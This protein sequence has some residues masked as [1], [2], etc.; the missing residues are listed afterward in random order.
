MRRLQKKYGVILMALM[1]QEDQVE[2]SAYNSQVVTL[3]EKRFNRCSTL[4]GGNLYLRNTGSGGQTQT[5]KTTISGSQTKSLTI[6]SD[7]VGIQSKLFIKHPT[8]A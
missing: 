2:Q 7:T 5:I 6:K 1:Q 4:C 3:Q 8:A